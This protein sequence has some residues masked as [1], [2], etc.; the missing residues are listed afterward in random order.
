MAMRIALA[1]VAAC[2]VCPPALS[3]TADPAPT[4]PAQ[5]A[6]A[7][8]PAPPPAPGSAVVVQLVGGDVLRGELV[9]ESAESVVLKHPILGQ[10]T[11]ARASVASVAVP[12]PPQAADP[13]GAQVPAQVAVAAADVSLGNAASSAPAAVAQPTPDAPKTEEKPPPSKWKFA[14][15]A[16][17]NYVDANVE[18][19][20]F[21]V[22]AGAVYEDPDVEKLQLSAE[23]FFRNVDSAQTDNNLLVTGVY[24]YFIKETRWLLFGKVQGQMDQL[25]N[26]EQ[27]LSGWG[28]VGYRFY[29]APPVGLTGKIGAGAT[30]EF[31]SIQQTNAELYGQLEGKWL[32]SDVQTLEASAWIA[33]SFEDFSQYLVL[34][35]AEWSM[36]IDPELGLSL[37]GGVRW[38]FQSQVPTGQNPDDTRVYAGLKLDF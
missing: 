14:V 9:S 21:R 33:P 23:Y 10:I 32:I 34:A 16:N 38:Q 8:A 5:T 19:L 30:R 20:D 37:L 3:Q 29:I 31:G 12:P 26:W 24:D 1:A 7:P 15:A 2:A 11:L 27:R 28:G 18:Q 17:V 36:K 22:A 35:R 4:A 25:Q 13:T 6:P